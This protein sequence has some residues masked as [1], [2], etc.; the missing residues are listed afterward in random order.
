VRDGSKWRDP[1]EETDCKPS[2][3]VAKEGEQS[4]RQAASVAET[5]MYSI[6]SGT[7]RV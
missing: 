3:V 7:V 4:Q 1:R 6:G 5:G 2:P